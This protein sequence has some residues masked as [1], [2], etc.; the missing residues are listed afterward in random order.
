MNPLNIISSHIPGVNAI[1]KN[2]IRYS[3]GLEGIGIGFALIGE[4]L[5]NSANPIKL[6]KIPP[7]DKKKNH[8]KY[9]Q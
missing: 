4:N 1:I 5:L 3:L 8:Y 2:P 9:S 7:L 6:K